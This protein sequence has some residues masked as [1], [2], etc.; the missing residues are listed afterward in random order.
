[1]Q[2]DEPP[3]ACFGF[4]SFRAVLHEQASQSPPSL[5]PP[6]PHPLPPCPAPLPSVLEP[7][8]LL[9]GFVL[10]LQRLSGLGEG[11]GEGSV[12]AGTREA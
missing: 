4:S 7:A 3:R 1:M 10:L 11:C 8:A 5:Q 9:P 12:C 2:E 6:C